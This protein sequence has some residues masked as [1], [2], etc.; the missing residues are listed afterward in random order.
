[1]SVL[2]EFPGDLHFEWSIFSPRASGDLLEGLLFDF[3]LEA[4]CH[5]HASQAEVARSAR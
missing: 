4:A 1:M 5:W 2:L 3:N